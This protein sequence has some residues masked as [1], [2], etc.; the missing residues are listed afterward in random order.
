MPASGT[1]TQ[2][3]KQMEKERL[4]F[5]VVLEENRVVGLVRERSFLSFASSRTG[6][7]GAT[8]TAGDAG[9]SVK[10]IMEPLEEIVSVSL[11]T[12]A[13]EVID[14]F[15]EHNIRHLPVIDNGVLSGIISGRDMLRPVLG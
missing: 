10:A 2:A 4:T 13:M 6:K 7:D 14:V 5:L 11:S 8:I 12:P 9:G 3:A 15:F 1:I